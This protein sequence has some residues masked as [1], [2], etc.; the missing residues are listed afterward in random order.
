MRPE[1]EQ[2]ILLLGSERPDAVESALALLQQTV[3]AFSMRVCGHREDAEDTMQDVLV[4]SIPHLP[5]FESPKALVVWLYTVAKN[6]CLMKRRKSKF[7]PKQELSLEELMPNAAELERLAAGQEHPDAGLLREEDAERV[8]AAVLKVPA[9]YRLILVLHDI[10]ELDTGQVAKVTGLRKGTVR[11]RLHRARLFLRRELS[12]DAG[13]PSPKR[14]STAP[15]RTTECKRMFAALSDYLDGELPDKSCE[16]IRQH[17]SG[18][19]PCIAFLN[20]LNRAVGTLRNNPPPRPAP[21][22]ADRIRKELLP[23][24]ASAKRPRASV[25]KL[26]L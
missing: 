1:V 7:A 10:E 8:R 17:L 25:A 3:F 4:K 24:I 13:L 20:D 14:A 16:D 6:Q 18:C 21:A 19:R 5:K 11:V 9:Q 22:V 2:A 26:R 12:R 23:L 15:K